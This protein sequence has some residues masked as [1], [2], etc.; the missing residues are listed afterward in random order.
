M[1]G[2]AAPGT[3]AERILAEARAREFHTA[4]EG[5][6]IALFRCAQIPQLQGVAI[7]QIKPAVAFIFHQDAAGARIADIKHQINI[8]GFIG[9]AGG[10]HIHQL[11]ARQDARFGQQFQKRDVARPMFAGALLILRARAPATCGAHVLQDFLK[12]LDQPGFIHEPACLFSVRH[13][14]ELAGAFAIC[15]RNRS[16]GAAFFARP[17][18]RIKAKHGVMRIAFLIRCRKCGNAQPRPIG[19]ALIIDFLARGPHSGHAEK[20][21]R[22]PTPQDEFQ[23]LAAPHLIDFLIG[24]A[25]ATDWVQKRAF[26]AFRQAAQID[27]AGTRRIGTGRQRLFPEG[28]RRARQA[29]QVEPNINELQTGLRHQADDLRQALHSSKP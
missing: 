12:P 10:H 3:A 22:Y 8:D 1:K 17:Q 2:I 26:A 24:R 20:R 27:Q 9:T 28:T 15:G 29:V 5:E 11:H 21:Q 6:G 19:R 18:R 4:F 25:T 13:K 16:I 14:G 7:V 23:S